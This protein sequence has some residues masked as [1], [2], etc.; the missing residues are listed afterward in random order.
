MSPRSAWITGRVTL[1]A[2]PRGGPGVL[3]SSSTN[4]VNEAADLAHRVALDRGCSSREPS[5]L[6][7]LSAL[8]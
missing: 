2:P 8:R 5:V 4:D 1:A 6:S 7:D 3:R